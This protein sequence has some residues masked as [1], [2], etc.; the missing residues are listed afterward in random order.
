[1]FKQLQVKPNPNLSSGNFVKKQ[2]PGGW[3]FILKLFLNSGY[4]Y[5]SAT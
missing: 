4:R 2:P 5:F 1:M 3:T